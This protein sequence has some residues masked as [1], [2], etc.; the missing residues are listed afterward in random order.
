MFFNLTKPCFSG[1]AL[2]PFAARSA[3]E[4]GKAEGSYKGEVWKYAVGISNLP[5]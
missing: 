5:L 3:V 4:P 2:V 1:L